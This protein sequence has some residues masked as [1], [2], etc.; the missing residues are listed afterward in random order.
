MKNIFSL[1]GISDSIPAD[2]ILNRQRY[3]LF[4]IS[5]ILG[6]AVLAFLVLQESYSEQ[7][8][9][10]R[11]FYF[12]ATA[13]ALLIN[14]FSLQRHR[15][16]TAAYICSIIAGLALI[17]FV[18][19]YNGGIRNPDF[20]YMGSIILY[21]YILLENKGGRITLGL[22]LVNIIFFYILTDFTEPGVYIS[23]SLAERSIDSKHLYTVI[24]SMVMMTSL[25]AYL[26]YSKNAVIDIIEV[27]KGLL[28]QK[29]AELEEL[30][31]VASETV[32][33]VIITD[34][35]GMVEWVNDG[36]TR[37]M[38][39]EVNEVTGKPA[40]TYLFG[41]MSDPVTRDLLETRQFATNNFSA[42]IIKYRKNGELIWVQENVTRIRD[43]EENLIKYI[44]IESDITD[45]KK[46]E[47]RMA[48]Y[49]K[50]LE[51]T[52]KELDKFAYV[53]SHDLKAPLRAIG[54]LTGWIEEDAGHLL[55]NEVRKN[56]NLIKERVVRMEALINGI[57]DYSKVAKKNNQSE[58]F[59]ANTL[60]RETI[61]ML[62][63]QADCSMTIGNNLPQMNADKIKVQQVFINLISNAIKFNSRS[64]KQ[65]TIGSTE[66]PGHFHFTVADNGPGI[67]KRFHEKIFII[68]QTVN[69]RDE[70]ES[71][72]VGLA[73]VK[74]IIEEHEG[75]IWVESSP[76]NGSVFHFTWPKQRITERVRDNET[77][78]V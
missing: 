1:K 71:S 75:K 41:P 73:I 76:G 11:M 22:S 48:E 13:L 7:Q 57:L 32:N 35:D 28:I 2:D 56:F 49:L 70:F 6:V 8:N 52:N 61:D 33:S 24:I 27:S 74:K 53:V 55:P 15:N 78:K 77:S 10:N 39:Y 44:F 3:S 38:G 69:T 72:G 20:F 23:S 31:L 43:E 19:Y 34:R 59:D 29:N 18:T 14:F 58:T 37:L 40:G 64:N 63:Q 42:E 67:D 45:R 5:S 66:E 47:E 68:F 9:V 36:F 46:S 50:N 4:S 54:N 62:G 25:S 30:S 51:K 12:S 16:I 60:V 65:V 17:H 26:A 21:S